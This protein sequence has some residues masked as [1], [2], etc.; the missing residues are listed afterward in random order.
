MTPRPVRERSD[1]ERQEREHENSYHP[2]SL[3]L[4]QASYANNESGVLHE[5]PLCRKKGI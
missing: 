1:G 4:T 5:L 3:R 2:F